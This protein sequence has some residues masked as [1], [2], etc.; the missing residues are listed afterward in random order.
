MR[1]VELQLMKALLRWPELLASA[2]SLV[3]LTL[4]QKIHSQPNQGLRRQL[5]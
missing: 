5:E 2:E 1:E 3:Q 4:V